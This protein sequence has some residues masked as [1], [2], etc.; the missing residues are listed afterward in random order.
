[1]W[2]K[3]I[4]SVVFRFPIFSTLCEEGRRG[5]GYVY[6]R[7]GSSRY[8]Y[9]FLCMDFT[10]L[11]W[12]KCAICLTPYKE[13]QR[14]QNGFSIRFPNFPHCV[15]GEGTSRTCLQKSGGVGSS[16][17]LSEFL[18][19]DLPCLLWKKV[20]HLLDFNFDSKSYP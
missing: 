17:Y 3:I 19:M 15:R 8:L 18:C 9:E 14:N 6:K 11:F 13:N 7:V 1:M 12:K 4:Q 5:L 16:R 20:C 2:L 10:C